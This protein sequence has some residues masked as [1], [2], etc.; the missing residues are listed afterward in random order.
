VAG[1]TLRLEQTNEFADRRHCIWAAR[2]LLHHGV[3][4]EC[5]KRVRLARQCGSCC[6]QKASARE[7]RGGQRPTCWQCRANESREWREHSEWQRA[8][9]GWGGGEGSGCGHVRARRRDATR[10][11][12]T[13]L[14]WSP[15]GGYGLV[16]RSSLF[17]IFTPSQDSTWMTTTT[18]S[19][20]S[21]LRTRSLPLAPHATSLT[22]VRVDAEGAMLLQG[23]RT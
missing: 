15:I 16:L 8:D 3:V 12:P 9:W 10:R 11:V 23:Q 21:S 14:D 6:V 22:E 1:R 18:L 19:I 4:L 5:C 7:R 17:T 20:L 13:H 2:Y